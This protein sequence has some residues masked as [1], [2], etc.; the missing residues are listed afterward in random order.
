MHLALKHYRLWDPRDPRKRPLG[1]GL[2]P[3][4]QG[5]G[6]TPPPVGFTWTTTS[7]G[8]PVYDINGLRVF[9][10]GHNFYVGA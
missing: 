6:G 3:P 8:Q 9:D 4:G 10:D 2:Y 7:A 5:G 1:C